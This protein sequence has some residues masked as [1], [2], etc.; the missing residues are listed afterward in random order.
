MSPSTLHR[1]LARASLAAICAMGLVLADGAPALAQFYWPWQTRPAPPPPPP[2]PP[3]QRAPRFTPRPTSPRPQSARP[4]APRQDE[5]KSDKA[6][7]ADKADVP[8]PEPPPPPY[9]PQLLR[10]SEILGAL[11]FLRPLCG[12]PDGQTWRDRMTTLLDAEAS[13]QT[14]RERLAGAYNKGYREYAQ[15]YRRCTPA[16][17]LIIDRYAGEGGKLSRE[18]TGRFGG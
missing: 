11:A 14:R 7:K 16:A 8:A 15:I 3:V 18:L 2:P 13:S 5:K 12:S 10:L 6:D 9:E 4:A 1:S 17:E